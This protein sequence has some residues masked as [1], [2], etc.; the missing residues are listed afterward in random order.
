MAQPG[1]GAPFSTRIL[2]LA[3]EK[4]RAVN[5]V[6]QTGWRTGRFSNVSRIYTVGRFTAP[7]FTRQRDYRKADIAVG[8]GRTPGHSS[9]FESRA[10]RLPQ[11]HAR[12]GPRKGDDA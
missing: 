10:F 3:P 9:A 8:A 7:D 6:V 12:R 1:P 2:R 4:G 5:A 11:P